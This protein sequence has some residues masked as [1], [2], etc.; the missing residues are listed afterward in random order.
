MSEQQNTQSNLT[1]WDL[2]KTFCRWVGKCCVAFLDVLLKQIKISFRKWYIVLPVVALGIAVSLYY[3][4]V[5]N[6]KYKAEGMAV[7]HGPMAAE[8]KEALRP[9]EQAMPANIESDLSLA[10]VLNCAPECTKGIRKVQTYYIIDYLDNVTPDMVDKKGKHQLDDT[11]NVVSNNFLQ[12]EVYT[13][14]LAS[15]EDFE[16]ALVDYVNNNPIMKSKYD[17][18]H[19]LLENELEICKN[20]LGYLDSLTKVMYYNY[21][22]GI[23]LDVSA[24]KRTGDLKL[25]RPGIDPIHDQILELLQ[26]TKLVEAEL[27]TCTQPLM[28]ISHITPMPKAINNR[29]KCL[30]TGFILSWILGLCIAWLVEDR[31]EVRQWLTT[32]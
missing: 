6:R 4:R 22:N 28:F 27:S 11:L 12:F 26:H 10:T 32:K 7:I 19:A 2:I 15:L 23:Q 20:Q 18:H 31:A 13:K 25:G 17:V 16:Q 5:E 3:S 24:S 8:V 29:I 30:I 1:L 14:D 21:S 9:I